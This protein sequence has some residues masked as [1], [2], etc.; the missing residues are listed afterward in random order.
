MGKLY[1][2]NE[3][4]ERYGVKTGTVISWIRDKKLCAIRISGSKMYRVSE[5]DLMKFEAER[6]TM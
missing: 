6:R 2:C 5:E 4:A 1:T 3:V